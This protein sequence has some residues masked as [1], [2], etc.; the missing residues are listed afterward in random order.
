MRSLDLDLRVE[1]L[2][3]QHASAR[4]QLKAHSQFDELGK[5]AEIP[6][7]LAEYIE[8]YNATLEGLNNLR[9]HPES[10]LPRYLLPVFSSLEVDTL[11]DHGQSFYG[12]TTLKALDTAHEGVGE[13]GLIA[14]LAEFAQARTKA[15]NGHRFWNNWYN[16]LSELDVGTSPSGNPVVVLAHLGILSVPSRLRQAY[17]EKQIDGA[18]PYSEKE[19]HELLNGKLP[20]GSE[21]NVVQ[22]SEFLRNGSGN[23]PRRYAVVMD[24][25]EAQKHPAGYQKTSAFYDNPVFI[26]GCGGKEKLI[27]YLKR[28]VEI[29]G[30]DESYCTK[31]LI[32]TSFDKPRGRVLYLNSN[33]HGLDGIDDLINNGRFVGVA[34]EAHR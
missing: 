21:I 25:K 31:H 12:G 16:G 26:A 22:F 11:L 8:T 20:D 28:V 10:I 33:N 19:F 23:L 15:P 7:D 29:R 4:D 32:N 14:T 30:K 9:I 13:N 3:Q 17:N 2:A 34:P 1:E 5:M 18:A 24:L 6:D 27:D